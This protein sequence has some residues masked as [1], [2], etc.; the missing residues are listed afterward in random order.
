MNDNEEEKW[1]DNEDERDEEVEGG[2]SNFIDM[3][4]VMDKA[5]GLPLSEFFLETRHNAKRRSAMSWLE[6]CDI[7]TID[8]IRSYGKKVREKDFDETKESVA[9]E[10]NSKDVFDSQFET[11][12][13]SDKIVS[14]EEDFYSLT[15]LMLAW[16]NDA[17]Y[18]NSSTVPEAAFNLG[19]YSAIEV[20]RRNGIVEVKGNGTLLSKKTDYVLTKK[21]SK[22]TK[23]ELTA[24]LKTIS[25]MNKK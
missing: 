6:T 12:D 8:M 16:E 22:M 18:I 25:K 14:D 20:L 7:D 17:V 1:D 2:A 24:A 21:C 4:E 15:L 19:M 5:D 10:N 23:K 9:T 11:E 13:D 3:R